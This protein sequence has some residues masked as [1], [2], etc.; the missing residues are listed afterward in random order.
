MPPTEHCLAAPSSFHSC[1]S[2]GIIAPS[3]MLGLDSVYCHTQLQSSS[4]RLLAGNAR[5]ASTKK[6]CAFLVVLSFSITT[7]LAQY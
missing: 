2:M 5:E 7:R 6:A 3:G 1:K 4:Q